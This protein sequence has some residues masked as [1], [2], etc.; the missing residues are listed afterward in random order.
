MI[1]KT[2]QLVRNDRGAGL[3][4]YCILVGLISVL[5][6][7]AVLKNGEHVRTMFETAEGAL[8]STT[9]GGGGG[10]GDD[11]LDLPVGDPGG[12]GG[13]PSGP[14]GGLMPTGTWFVT[15]TGIENDVTGDTWEPSGT[16]WDRLP[17]EPTLIWVQDIWRGPF[18]IFDADTTEFVDEAGGR[19]CVLFTNQGHFNPNDMERARRATPPIH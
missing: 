14:G 15:G 8:A 17:T 19:F 10:T 13:G 16:T 11:D 6:T 12:P 9:T 2:R 7:A 4:E 5:A 18:C 3:I 1:C